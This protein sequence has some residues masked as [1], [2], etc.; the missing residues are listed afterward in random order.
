MGEL[1]VYIFWAP[2]CY[3]RQVKETER[4][5]GRKVEVSKSYEDLV[6]RSESKRAFDGG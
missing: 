2:L 4:R 5:V 3:D 1:C 6:S